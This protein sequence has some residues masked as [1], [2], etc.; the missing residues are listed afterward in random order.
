MLY[1]S[2]SRYV[3][4]GAGILGA[5][6]A[7][8][9]ASAGLRVTLLDQDRPGRAAS[10]WSF[11]WLNSNDKTPRPYHD[12]NHAGMKAWAELAPDLDGDAWYRP[13]GHVEL[14]TS[15]AAELEARVRRLAGWGYP[16]SLID[17]AEAER[18]EPS[19]RLPPT[20]AALAW[21]PQEGYLLTEPLIA[22][23]VA[24][25]KSHGADVLTGEP[26]QVTGLE[27]GPCA[28][29]RVR[30]A[31]GAVLAA[32]EV[33]CCA[34]RW[35]PALA[36]VPLV[37][38]DTPGS[39]APAL[40]VRVGPVAPSGPVR[41]VHTPEISLRPHSGGLLHLEAPDAAVD[42]HTPE[43]EL[44]RWAAELLRRARRTVR[45][46]DDAQVVEF[47]V[48]V[49][50]LPADGQSIVGRVPG[51]PGL[52]VAVTH[53]GVTLAAH[54]SRLIAADLTTDPPHPDLAPYHPG[55][56]AAAPHPPVF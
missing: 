31:A 16:A 50:P 43:P 24:Y 53:S 52:Y 38:W 13:A 10:R 29:P 21:F 23:L 11:A 37:P 35:T 30:T 28:A 12:L 26:G 32:D 1:M 6:V 33:V 56:F 22:R 14:A 34:G 20:A 5:A 46:L 54:L 27:T 7:A 4:I 36:A 49:R 39:T 8:R 18:I 44:R 9:L 48:C 51:A 25:A 15:G 55:R 41:L 17:A 19:L 40:V 3:V 42:L 47:Q 45:G 2:S